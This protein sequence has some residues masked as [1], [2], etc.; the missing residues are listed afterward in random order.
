MRALFGLS[1]LFALSSLAQAEEGKVLFTCQRDDGHAF[2]RSQIILSSTGDYI[3][4]SGENLTAE[5]SEVSP[6]NLARIQIGIFNG[7]GLYLK[8]GG[9]APPF[10]ETDK[11]Y[12][13][14]MKMADDM[15]ELYP[16]VNVKNAFTLLTESGAISLGQPLSS[17]KRMFY[18]T[19]AGTLSCEFKGTTAD[20]NVLTGN[21]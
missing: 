3:I 19:S 2:I 13:K 4:Q 5:R 8:Y 17:K 6:E 20:L 11:R 15:E 18:G 10:K 7:S 9:Q 14:E 1:L 12:I 21:L 16:K